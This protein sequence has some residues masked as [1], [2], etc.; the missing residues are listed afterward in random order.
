MQ[1]SY[2]SVR[3]KGPAGTKSDASSSIVISKLSRQTDKILYG[4]LVVW[5]GNNYCRLPASKEDVEQG[6]L[7]IALH[8]GVG[9]AYK[10][11]S[12]VSVLR[13]GR[14]LVE[15]QADVEKVGSEVF[16][17]FEP[18]LA[19]TFGVKEGPN[20]AK[21]KGACYTQSAKKGEVVELEINLLGG[22]K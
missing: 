13:Q 22:S 12:T 5:E 21:L 8:D 1:I 16:V 4:T 9:T 7:G 19:G 17:N 11:S 18:A 15:A 3:K 10:P 6:A 2:S 20:A 14:V